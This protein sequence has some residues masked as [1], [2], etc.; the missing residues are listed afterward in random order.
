MNDLEI[1]YSDAIKRLEKSFPNEEPER[2]ARLKGAVLHACLDCEQ[3]LKNFPKGQ[4]DARKWRDDSELWRQEQTAARRDAKSQI[5]AIARIAQYAKIYKV[6]CEIA[7]VQA[8]FSGFSNERK[9]LSDAFANALLKYGEILQEWHAP[10]AFMQTTHV[11]NLLLPLPVKQRSQSLRPSTGLMIRLIAT[12]RKFTAGD[13]WPG[14]FQTGEPFPVVGR[15]CYPL[16]AAFTHVATGDI[17]ESEK[18]VSQFLKNHPGLGLAG[19]PTPNS[20]SSNK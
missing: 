11:F 2:L 20:Q 18:S 13:P 10:A 16:A 3:Y 5:D 4:D 7:L 19:W 15:P 12:F 14:R 1:R 8:G 6:Q 17:I 9:R